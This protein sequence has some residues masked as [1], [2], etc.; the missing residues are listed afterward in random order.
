MMK[1]AGVVSLF[2]AVS[3]MESWYHLEHQGPLSQSFA[4]RS[5]QSYSFQVKDISDL[6]GDF[7]M[8]MVVQTGW[9]TIP[10]TETIAYHMAFELGT[11]DKISA[12]P[13]NFDIF[14][15]LPVANSSAGFEKWEAGLLKRR[16][17]ASSAVLTDG[18]NTVE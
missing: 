14:W 17:Q 6:E 12:I 16:R 18:Y 10:N 7:T 13:D 3:A 1:T 8:N 11:I 2:G 15:A 5:T 9:V 4:A